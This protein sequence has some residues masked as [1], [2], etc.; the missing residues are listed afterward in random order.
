MKDL[1]LYETAEQL[2]IANFR[3]NLH[4]YATKINNA[5]QSEICTSLN[6]D[7]ISQSA[8]FW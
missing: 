2:E 4:L 1:K 3:I 8:Y 6:P 7:E 5:K